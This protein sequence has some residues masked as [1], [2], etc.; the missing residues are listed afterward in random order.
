MQD[1]GLIVA[2]LA[3]IV[4]NVLAYGVPAVVLILAVAFIAAGLDDGGRRW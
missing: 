2:V 4:E 3:R 1:L